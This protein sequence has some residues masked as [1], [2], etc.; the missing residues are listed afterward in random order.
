M[1]TRRRTL[2]LEG[3]SVLSRRPAYFLQDL[4]LNEDRPSKGLATLRRATTES[5]EQLVPSRYRSSDQALANGGHPAGGAELE[6]HRREAAEHAQL[7]DTYREQRDK[8]HSGWGAWEHAHEQEAPAEDASLCLTVRPEASLIARPRRNLA[9]M[10]AVVAK[11]RG[12]DGANGGHPTRAGRSPTRES[13]SGRDAGQALGHQEIHMTP[14]GAS[15]P[16]LREENR[17]PLDG[18]FRL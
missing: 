13:P 10:N 2:P 7:A 12:V 8:L 1:A 11:R 6:R 16:W 9:T 4:Q 18:G 3:L 17:H 14:H 15:P 5:A